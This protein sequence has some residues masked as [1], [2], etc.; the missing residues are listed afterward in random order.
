MVAS[1]YFILVVLLGIA[2]AASAQSLVRMAQLPWTGKDF[3]STYDNPIFEPAGHV[4][5]STDSERVQW[6]DSFGRVRINKND[7]DSPFFA[8][9]VLTSDLNSDSTVIHS[10][11]DEFDLAVGMHWGTIADWRISTITGVGYSSTH[12][13]VNEKGL[14]G[15]GSITAEHAIGENDAVLL[16]V[17]YAGNAGLLP[18]VPL[19]G[20]AWMHHDE[21]WNVMLGYPV[22]N[23]QWQPVSKVTVTAQYQVPY[24]GSVNVEYI[25]WEHFGFYANTSNWMQGIVIAKEDSIDRQFFQIR[26]VEMGIRCIFNPLVDAGVGVGYAFDQTISEGYDV[27]SLRGLAHLSNEPYLSI[28]IH[29]R[30]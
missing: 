13:F 22:N 19:P 5:G 20:F 1:R 28:V 30:M 6:W 26:R 2:Q 14:F 7:P 27:R 17:D 4:S 9:R 10:T 23:V 3:T 24:T 12:P 21:H 15:I 8:Y 29:G 16:S 18:D 11:M 25:P